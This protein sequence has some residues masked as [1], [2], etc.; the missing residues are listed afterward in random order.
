MSASEWGRALTLRGTRTHIRGYVREWVPTVKDN[1][2]GG[3]RA[4]T[5]LISTYLHHV[6][7]FPYLSYLYLCAQNRVSSECQNCSLPSV[8]RRSVRGLSTFLLRCCELLSSCDDRNQQ[9]KR[10]KRKQENAWVGVVFR[11]IGTSAGVSEN[12]WRRRGWCV[13]TE[14]GDPFSCFSG[15]GFWTDL[16]LWEKFSSFVSCLAQAFSRL[17]LP[18]PKLL[19]MQ[20]GTI[21][22]ER[23]S[24]SGPPIR[25]RRYDCSFFFFVSCSWLVQLT[26][27]WMMMVAM[28]DAGWKE[29]PPTVASRP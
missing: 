26:M 7:P 13:K 2:E 10:K 12:E 4:E 20:M 19:C 17:P 3:R 16:D 27:M 18:S 28:R 25:R 14:K 11:M 1:E 6:P 9:A 15:N 21:V 23:M 29:T 24:F 8:G 22:M 5:K